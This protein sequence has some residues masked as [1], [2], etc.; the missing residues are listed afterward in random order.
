MSV[1]Q[2]HLS[3]LL[4][5]I[6]GDCSLIF[7]SFAAKHKDSSKSKE[8]Y[9]EAAGI[10]TPSKEVLSFSE[11]N[12]NPPPSAAAPP[13]SAYSKLASDKTLQLVCFHP[14]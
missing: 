2:T 10:S 3:C 11:K 14:L 4:L 1:L 8:G 9:E 12:H 13:L 6:F 5:T 7:P